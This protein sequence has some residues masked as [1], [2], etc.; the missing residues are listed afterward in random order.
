[1]YYCGSWDN[2]GNQGLF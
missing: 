1:D 2:S